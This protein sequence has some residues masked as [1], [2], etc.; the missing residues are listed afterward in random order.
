MSEVYPVYETKI[1]NSGIF[2]FKEVYNFLFEWFRSL[3]YVVLEQK[4]SE[5]IRPT[6]KEIG[7]SWLCL[8]KINDYVRFRVKVS[9]TIANLVEVEITEE[10]IKLKK[11]KGDIEIKFSG[12]LEKDYENKWEANP[13][14][15]FLRGIY[16]KYI[17]RSKLEA[18]EDKLAEEIEESSEQ[19]KA[20]LALE[21]RKGF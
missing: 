9:I 13:I 12:H 10:G 8:K 18:Y 17:I 15:K 20:F 5:K 21:G 19:I 16:D 7:I 11:D 6:G 2:N 14:T 3:E 4:Y 1:A